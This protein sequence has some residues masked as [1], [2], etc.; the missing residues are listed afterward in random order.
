MR[1]L[2]LEDE[3][4]IRTALARGL[5]R[6]Q[7]QVTACGSL[8][9][10]RAALQQAAPELLITD[11]KLP[12]GSG[13]DMAAEWDLPFI[14]MSGYAAFDDAV[15]ALRLGCVD[16]FTK[17]VSIHDLRDCLQQLQLRPRV[18]HEQPHLLLPGSEPG[19]VQ[20]ESSGFTVQPLECQDLSWYTRAEAAAA[21]GQAME[22]ARSLRERQVLAELMQCSEEGRVVI[23]RAAERWVAWL[24]ADL[25]Q[26]SGLSPERRARIE[27]LATAVWWRPQGVLVELGH[28]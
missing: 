15:Q 3:T 24:Q 16:F 26:A 27:E 25:E 20:V 5:E 12:D 21:Y 17:P 23:N 2:L 9:E 18:R 7:H 19:I 8:A 22:A 6:S 13:L 11:L 14:V 10:A 4:A 28:D 1:L